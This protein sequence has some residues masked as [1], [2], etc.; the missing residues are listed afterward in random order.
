[1]KRSRL[2]NALKVKK[3][4]FCVAY[5]VEGEFDST[6]KQENEYNKGLKWDSASGGNLKLAVGAQ[7]EENQ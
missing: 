5:I 4:L 7:C 3:Y 1:M 6:S 2:R